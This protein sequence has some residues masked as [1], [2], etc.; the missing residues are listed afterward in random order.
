MLPPGSRPPVTADTGDW[1]ELKFDGNL[2]DSSGNGHQLGGFGATY[3]ATPNRTAFALPKTMGAPSWSNWVSLRAGY[4]AQLD[5]TASY[6]LADASPSVTYFW[7]Q[8]SGPSQL[9]FADRTSATPTVT[10]LVFGTYEFSLK[11]TD[12]AGNTSTATLD[13]GAVAT[14]DNGVV[15]NSDPNVD[16]I[17][18]PMIAF[19]RNPWG[20]ADERALAATNLRYAA[21]KAQNL[22]PPSWETA[23]GGTVSYQFSGFNG[24]RVASL[25][26]A[27]PD[28]Q[29]MSFSVPDA[30]GIDLTSLPT[31]VL[32]GPYYGQREDVRICGTSA[33][34][35]P[36]VL[37]VCYDGRGQANPQGDS[38]KTRAQAWAAGTNIFQMRVKGS[39]TNFL[40]RVCPAG[41]GPAGPVVYNTGSITLSP[42]S[43]GVSGSG[44]NWTSAAGITANNVIVRVNAKHGGAPFVFYAYMTVLNDSSHLTMSRA[45]PVDADPGTFPY[46]LI[47]AESLFATL[48]YTRNGTDSSDAQTFGYTAGCESA[49]DMYLYGFHDLGS[50][51]PGPQ[52][53]KQYSYMNGLGYASAFGVNF[54][55][56]DLAHRALYYR[57]GWN[58]ALQAARA[59]GDYYVRSPVVA[60]GDVGGIPLL[61]GGGV[62]GGFA[63]AILDS[64]HPGATQWADLRGLARSGSIGALGC[65]VMDTRDSSYLSSFLA[66]AAVFD[67]DPTQQAKWS[68]SLNALYNREMN[69]KRSDNSWAHGFLWGQQFGPLNMT[70]GSATVTGTNLPQGMCFGVSSGQV[71]LVNGSAQAIPGLGSFVPGNKIVVSAT[72]NGAPYLSSLY[73]EINTDGT[74]T[75]GALWPGDTGTYSYVIENND[76]RTTIATSNDDPQLAKEWACTWNSPTQVTL[77]RPWDG[78]S[79]SNAWAWQ[80]VVAGYGQQPYMVGIKTTEL[81]LASAVADPTLS[82][83]FATLAGQAATWVHDVGYDPPTQGLHYAR[84]YQECEPQ[85]VPPPGIIFPSRT[86]GC[87]QGQAPGSISAARAL[88]PEAASAITVF[89]QSNPTPDAKQWGDTVYG[90]IWGNPAFTT[91]GVYSDSNYVNDL[92]SN[93]SLAGP[94]WTGFFFGMGMAHQWPAARLGGT[95]P[96]SLRKVYVSV[97]RG[98]AD[99]SEIMV[100]S[101]SGALATYKCGS[102]PV[103]AI[104]VDDR[105]GTHWF[106][107]N[108]VSGG[109][110]VLQ[111]EPALLA[112][113]TRKQSTN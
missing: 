53:G 33:K 32:I 20:F 58:V 105:Q 42:G 79:E 85:T 52:T 11:V 86:P 47:S 22:N 70:N 4:P 66:L 45:F 59:M 27:I 24:P 39:A 92:T 103:C 112:R 38:Y 5:G 8:V 106:R 43:A 17:F 89:Y 75:L 28:G 74:A 21:Y 18:G 35:G 96:Q 30:S 100:A 15:I 10:G 29:A 26:A 56:E 9:L 90:S 97:N 14:D 37:T 7:Q 41:A 25:A 61:Y 57:S 77:N 2:R 16:K 76:A 23:L 84:V 110:T 54:Y 50:V 40:L 36:A 64:G 65:N 6:S 67:P 99:S 101:P 83:G 12:A 78:P 55:G 109:Q 91:G 13:V 88:T 107:V 69:C 108:Y 3:V 49:T 44:T 62:I 113:P 48:H 111:S 31:R 94:K 73:Y 81:K 72:L 34:T 60:G 87:D 82:S 19:G 80:G 46:A 51:N 95:A 98:T 104:Q 93:A 1:T 102:D 63:S 68:T 71:F